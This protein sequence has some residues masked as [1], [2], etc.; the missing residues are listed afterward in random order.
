MP[1]SIHR[2]RLPELGVSPTSSPVVKGSGRRGQDIVLMHSNARASI[3]FMR[4]LVL[5]KCNPAVGLMISRELA[6]CR[7]SE[8]PAAAATSAFLRTRNASRVPAMLA[9]EL[10]T[11]PIDDVGIRPRRDRG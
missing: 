3:L 9:P 6:P 2:S 10:S 7:L 8:P 11:L 1:Q 5:V 4:R